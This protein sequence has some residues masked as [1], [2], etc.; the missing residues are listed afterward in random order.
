MGKVTHN[1]SVIHRAIADSFSLLGIY[2]IGPTAVKL[3]K[4]YENSTYSSS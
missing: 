1:F 2:F 3:M 4:T